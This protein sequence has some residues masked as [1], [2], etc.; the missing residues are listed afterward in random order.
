MLGR[1]P[2]RLPGENRATASGQLEAAAAAAWAEAL[3]CDARLLGEPAAHLV[4]GGGRL[5]DLNGVYIAGVA[6]G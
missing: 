3:G 4:P 6:A 1:D 5:Q 2:G